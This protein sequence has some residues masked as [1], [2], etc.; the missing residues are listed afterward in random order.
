MKS[1]ILVLLLLLSSYSLG[2]VITRNDTSGRDVQPYIFPLVPIGAAVA[3]GVAIIAGFAIRSHHFNSAKIVF[4]DGLNHGGIISYLDKDAN[5][6]QANLRHGARSVHTKEHCYFLYTRPNCL[7][8]AIKGAPGTPSHNNLPSLVGG[9][10]IFSASPCAEVCPENYL[11]KIVGHNDSD[12]DDVLY[13]N[14]RRRDSIGKCSI[15]DSSFTVGL[16]ARAGLRWL[17]NNGNFRPFRPPITDVQY[18]YRDRPE[19]VRAEIRRENLG[20]GTAPSD[21]MRAYVRERGRPGDQAGHIIAARLG[22]TGR[23][24]YNIFPQ[25]PNINM[26]HWNKEEGRI[27]DEVRDHGR[28]IMEI[29]FHYPNDRSTRP[30]YFVVRVHAIERGADPYIMRFENP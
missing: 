11:Y 12:L 14:G 29:N 18:G 22:G 27:R 4:Y 5:C 24:S 21:A 20:H 26:G 25:S 19:Y 30:D 6:I 9:S 2:S 15:L 8:Q 1:S 3:A 16:I 7:G 17:R 13:G 23:D 10:A 28:V